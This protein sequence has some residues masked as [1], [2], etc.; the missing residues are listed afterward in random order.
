MQEADSEALRNI[1]DTVRDVTERVKQLAAD[2]EEL[3]QSSAQTSSDLSA[4]KESLAARKA[5]LDQAMDSN[6]RNGWEA[7]QSSVLEGQHL[8][9]HRSACHDD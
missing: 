9:A 8:R 5:A 2:R 4:A 6:R 3:A 1:E 7:L